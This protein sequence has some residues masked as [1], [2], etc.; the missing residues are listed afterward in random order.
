[1]RS[2]Q[3]AKLDGGF[4]NAALANAT[5]SVYTSLAAAESVWRRAVDHCACFLFQTFEWNATWR[6]TV[7]RTEIVSEHIVHVAAA[8]GRTLLILPLAIAERRGLRVLR[9][10]GHSVSGYNAPLID[11]DFAGS[12]EAAD[13]KRLWRSVRALIPQIDL[14]WLVRMPKTIDGVRNPMLELS[15]VQH[16]DDAYAAML[17]GSFKEFTAGR[18]A[19]FFAQIRRHRRRLEKRGSVDICFP[20]DGAQRIEIVRALARQRAPQDQVPDHAWQQRA[21]QEFYE[22]LT[23]CQLQAG[24]ILVACLRVGDQVAAALWGA[25]FGQ[26]CYFLVPSYAEEWRK[27]SAGRILTEEVL[28]RCISQGGIRIF[29]LTVGNEHYRHTWSDHSLSL[30]EYLEAGSFKGM[31]FVAWQRTRTIARGTRH[32]QA[33]VRGAMLR[34]RLL[35]QREDARNPAGSAQP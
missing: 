20:A 2:E 6:E 3:L 33:W 11:R 32:A 10:L 7:G 21:T 31:I 19:Q 13:F 4:Q 27:F 25:I 26:R 35:M 24:N 22:R 30:H 28:Q 15:G 14:V 8:D 18:S 1:M 12:V 9:F 34:V 23:N 29:D 5:M 16:T 17:P